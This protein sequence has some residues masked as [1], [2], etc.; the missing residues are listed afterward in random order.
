MKYENVDRDPD[1]RK[2]SD[3]GEFRTSWMPRLITFGAVVAL[4]VGVVI[5]LIYYSPAWGPN[6]W[7]N[8]GTWVAGI[9]TSLAVI[10]AVWQTNNAN[11]QARSAEMR[12]YE[13]AREMANRHRAEIAAADQRLI[14]Q[15]NAQRS[16]EQIAAISRIWGVLAEVQRHVWLV[17]EAMHK[18]EKDGESRELLDL[19]Y[20]PYDAAKSQVK[21]AF[22]TSYMLVH[23]TEVIALLE[24][25]EDA[26]KALE[27]AVQKAY[28]DH[29]NTLYHDQG[30]LIS[31]MHAVNDLR[32]ETIN[33][34]KL[35][36]SPLRAAPLIP[37]HTSTHPAA[38]PEGS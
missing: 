23:D 29:D 31:A 10:V 12:A 33:L 17:D 38:S 7:G 16:I 25:T 27:K 34:V 21:A 19:A 36:I 28:R 4:V 22:T 6:Q 24:K 1:L 8:V 35:K 37:G 9:A 32:D 26:Q 14:D 2:S 13:E 18:I 3:L 15:L 30:S 5:V 20:D 11:K